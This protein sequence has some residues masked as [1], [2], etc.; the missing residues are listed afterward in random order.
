MWGIIYWQ[1]VFDTSFSV[2]YT[3]LLTFDMVYAIKSTALYVILFLMLF[4]W[5][6]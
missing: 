4:Y 6:G 5:I 1:I 2:I 3:L